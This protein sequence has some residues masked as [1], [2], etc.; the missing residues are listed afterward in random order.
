MDEWQIIGNKKIKSLHNGK[1][2]V[3]VPNDYEQT[4]V[5]LFCSCCQFPMKTLDDSVS[6]RKV[7]VCNHCNEKWTNKPG[8]EWPSGPDKTTQSWE[9]YIEFRA[10]IARPTINLK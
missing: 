2:V 5:P 7:G 9:E 3:L 10:F 1:V 4:V 8:V 6:F